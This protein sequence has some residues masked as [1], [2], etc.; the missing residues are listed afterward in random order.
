MSFLSKADYEEPRCVLC[1]PTDIT[2]IPTRR[3]LDKL[4][5]YLNTKDYDA[6]ERHLKYWLTEAEVG[7]DDRG[8]LTVLNEQI[9][10]YRKT[11]KPTE[12][13]QAIEAA[14]ALAEAF[15][16][17]I[18]Y[19]TTLVNAATAYKAFGKAAS[20]LPLYET[21]RTVYES[22]LPPT[23]GRLGG[24]YNNMALTVMELGDYA[25]AEMLFQKA[26]AIMAQQENGEIEMAITYCNLADL[27]SAQLGADGEKQIETYLDKAESLLD[28]PTLPRDGYY[29]FVCEKCA[30]TFGY[31]GYFL[32]ERKLM[33]QAEAIYER[34]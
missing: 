8:K 12:G 13:L 6:A 3:V 25:K 1:K 7:S 5:E 15:S 18:T 20:A 21:A 16:G 27:V 26:L 29:A 34:T 10:L 22:T 28:T 30:P 31:Y 17:T 9:G 2:P 33:K 19:G 23:D 11:D 24:L 32:T 14:L 4:D